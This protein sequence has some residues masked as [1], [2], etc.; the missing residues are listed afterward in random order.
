MNTHLVASPRHERS[1]HRPIHEGPWHPCPDPEPRLCESNG[2]A[3]DDDNND[4]RNDEESLCPSFWSAVAALLLHSDHGSLPFN[5]RHASGRVEGNEMSESFVESPGIGQLLSGLR[6]FVPQQLSLQA[7]REYRE[8]ARCPCRRLLGHL[9]HHGWR[10][11]RY[12]A[13][14]AT[15]GCVARI[16]KSVFLIF[17]PRKL[18]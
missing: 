13:I 17:E 14:F 9:P 3:T 11:Q 12:S 2:D 16:Q 6:E 7:Q 15:G 1:D 10:T 8:S 4:G 5:I 18:A